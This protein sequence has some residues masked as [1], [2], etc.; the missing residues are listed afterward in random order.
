M[1]TSHITL[2]GIPYADI[3]GMFFFWWAC[4]KYGAFVGSHFKPIGTY[5]I[6]AIS[7]LCFWA[8]LVIHHLEI[9][10]SV[11]EIVTIAVSSA[12]SIVPLLPK[13]VKSYSG[14]SQ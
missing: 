14:N 11:N 3:G 5:L 6:M 8:A 12:F 9:S 10:L 1:E 13:I 4:A 2:L 7:N